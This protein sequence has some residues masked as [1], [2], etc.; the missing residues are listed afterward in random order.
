LGLFF[1]QKQKTEIFQNH[2]DEIKERNQDVYRENFL[3][4]V[5]S[6]QQQLNKKFAE[7]ATKHA[8]KHDR[9]SQALLDQLT[10]QDSLLLEMHRKLQ[11]YEKTTHTINEQLHIQNEMKDLLERHDDLQNIYHQTLMERFD[12]QDS[13]FFERMN[14]HDSKVMSH[15]TKQE[16]Q[17][18]ENL[19]QQNTLITEHVERHH[20]QL[21][22][23]IQKMHAQLISY[24]DQQ[25]NQNSEQFELYIEKLNEYLN[26]HGEKFKKQSNK[27]DSIMELVSQHETQQALGFK[28]LN[29][30]ITENFQHYDAAFKEHF[31][32][33]DAQ[34]SNYVS[35]LDTNLMNHF[36]K[37]NEHLKEL[38]DHQDVQ[39]EQLERKLD[40]IKSTI[41]ERASDLSEKLDGHFKRFTEFFGNLFSKDERNQSISLPEEK[42]NKEKIKTQ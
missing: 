1:N 29:D 28:H 27:I 16:N 5:I 3:Q 4:S 42:E 32:N 18:T 30:S 36:E 14:Q 34:L 20:I 11:A 19:N 13:D 26:Q 21:N 2:K 9:Y 8:E 31:D 6:E 39:N 15:F 25:E 24:L 10:L 23:D 12:H 41:F 37:Q 17:M 33:K 7:D 40:F 22:K 35:K 38:V